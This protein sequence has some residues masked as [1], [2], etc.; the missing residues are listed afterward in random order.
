M[1]TRSTV[2]LGTGSYAP[3]RVLTNDDLAK[4]VDTSDEWIRTRTGIRERRIARPDETTSDMAVHAA[5]R[6][7]D[8]A[9]LTPADI[10]LLIVAT[11]TPDMPM[12]A[13]ACVLQ[14]KLGR[15]HDRCVFRSQCGLFGVR[16]RS[17][18]RLRHARLGPL[19]EGAGHRR[20]ED[21][22]PS[23]T[24]RIARRACCSAMAPGR[25]SSAR[26]IRKERGLIGTRL[27]TLGDGADL[28]YISHG[29]SRVAVN[30]ESIADRDHCIRMKGKE[31]FKLAVRAMDEAARDILEQHQL[32]AIRFPS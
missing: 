10:D 31:V 11:I 9:G 3:E 8:D 16:L 15:A 25:L 12:P 28:L 30:A 20:G 23:S 1:P 27:G 19:P 24:G 22:P 2:I 32:R 29:G 26:R 5:Q 7:L 14:H 21:F 4:M 17:R 18:Y 6:A 13:C